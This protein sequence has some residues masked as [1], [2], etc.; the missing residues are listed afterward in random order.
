MPV[1]SEY[2][3][4]C[5]LL[6]LTS[7]VGRNSHANV[8]L[9]INKASLALYIHVARIVQR[10]MTDRSEV[11]KLYC[12]VE[13]VPVVEASK[14]V[15]IEVESRSQTPSLRLRCQH[16]ALCTHYIDNL[17][18]HSPLPICNYWGHDQE[19]H[20]NI[21]PCTAWNFH[22]SLSGDIMAK[23][24]GGMWQYRCMEVVHISESPLWGAI[25]NL[26]HIDRMH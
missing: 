7:T 10:A 2:L 4:S 11:W 22:C 6:S 20:N 24:I 5:E 8:I 14:L 19:F 13:F 15:T 21:T 25:T 23:L 12:T 16:A 17:L 26:Q 3:I 9:W 18:S 1:S